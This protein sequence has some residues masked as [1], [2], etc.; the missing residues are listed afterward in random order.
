MMPDNIVVLENP[1]EVAR[2]AADRF[3]ELA[4]VAIT[5]RGR[6]SAALAG[7]STPKRTYELLAS[8]DY[9]NR[10]AWAKVHVFFGDE[11]CVGPEDPESNYRMARSAML[12]H[13]P[14][15]AQNVH[16]LVGEGAPEASARL[17]IDELR[18]FFE[19][20]SWPRFDL[21]FLGLGDDGHTLSLFP[22]TAALKEERA[23]VVANWVEKF[24][25]FR[26]T[27][28]AP[29]INRAVQI[30][31]LVTG[32]GKARRLPEVIRGPR[33]TERLPSQLIQPVDGSL[34]WFVDKAAAVY[35]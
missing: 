30:V 20:A 15:P 11:R 23:W 29:A 8:E 18:S 35:L 4:Q 19:G 2:A 5:G 6:F 31:F 9:R 28:T 17:Y 12:S 32:E 26:L 16:R 10:V 33:D 34:A 3:V 13:L 14:I 22:G 7:G 24:K 25:T 1:E 21:V 27:L